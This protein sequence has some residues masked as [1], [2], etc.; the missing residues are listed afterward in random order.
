MSE[1]TQKTK[2]FSVRLPPALIEQIDASAKANTR[3][4]TQEMQRA[5]EAYFARK[6][7]KSRQTP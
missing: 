4:R 3:T 6:Q 5:L 7:K 1:D 2:Q